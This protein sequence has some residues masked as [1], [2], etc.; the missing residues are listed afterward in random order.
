MKYRGKSEKGQAGDTFRPRS[1]W[2]TT[3]GKKG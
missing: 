3:K 2:D 1:R